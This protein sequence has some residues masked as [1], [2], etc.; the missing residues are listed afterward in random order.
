M[1]S[2][3]F[4]IAEDSVSDTSAAGMSRLP[5]AFSD[6]RTGSERIS[7]PCLVASICIPTYNRAAFLQETLDSIVAQ[8][9]DDLEITVA[10]NA[11]EDDTERLVESYR[12][13]YGSVRYFRWG[14][15]Q[16]ADRNY[17]KS[18]E[19]AAGRY[20]WAVVSPWACWRC[21]GRWR[22]RRSC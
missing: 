7:L 14:A 3:A 6:L 9:D 2:G 8:W 21:T 19:L 1:K 22:S 5:T 10:D 13:R 15:N 18:V 16:G 17:L 20:C 4:D 11:S 12:Q